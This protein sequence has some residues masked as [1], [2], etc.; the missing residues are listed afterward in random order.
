VSATRPG[1]DHL[2]GLEV[3][4]DAESNYAALQRVKRRWD[5]RNV[6][7]HTLSIRP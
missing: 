6:F 5:P 3:V 2:Y 1:A 7:H 4:V